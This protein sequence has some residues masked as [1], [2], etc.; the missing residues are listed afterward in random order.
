VATA[1]GSIVG[2]VVAG[3]VGVLLILLAVWGIKEYKK[4]SNLNSLFIK[5][6][7]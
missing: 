4:I 3:V 6:I 7:L 5:S 2:G 1:V